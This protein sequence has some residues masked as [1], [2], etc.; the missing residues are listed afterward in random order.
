MVYWNH[1]VGCTIIGDPLL[2][3]AYKMVGVGW[4]NDTVVEPKNR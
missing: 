4:D 3:N 2:E 1:L